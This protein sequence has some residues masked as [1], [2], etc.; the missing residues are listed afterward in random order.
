LGGEYVSDWKVPAASGWKGLPDTI[1]T[2]GTILKTG[3]EKV[4]QHSL[5]NSVGPIDSMVIY[6]FDENECDMNRTKRRK[7][8]GQQIH[9]PSNHDH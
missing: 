9:S 6:E 5:F 4:L 1:L 8:Y 7:K 3:M 2:K